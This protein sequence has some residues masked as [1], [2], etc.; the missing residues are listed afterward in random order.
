MGRLTDISQL[1]IRWLLRVSAR[2][3]V[4][5]ALSTWDGLIARGHLSRQELQRRAAAE[6]VAAGWQLFILI[7]VMDP[8]LAEMVMV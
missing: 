5:G 8:D 6:T 4:S 1:G 2:L 7:S 3:S